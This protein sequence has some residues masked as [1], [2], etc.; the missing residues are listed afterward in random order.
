MAMKRNILLLFLL[1]IFSKIDAQ[2]LHL[3]M[4][5]DYA[6]PKFGIVSQADEE[7][8]LNVFTTVEWAI[9]YKLSTTYLNSNNKKFDSKNVLKSINSLQTKPED[10]IVLFYSGFG[11]YPT[12][13]ES[14]FPSFK[15]SDYKKAPLS[16]D[17]I[18]DKIKVKT[19]RLGIVLADCRDSFQPLSKG[20]PPPPPQ[21][22]MGLFEDFRRIMLRKIFLEKSGILKVASSS[23]GE[24]TWK[25]LK[26]NNSVFVSSFRS[27][28]GIQINSKSTAN[29]SLDS[30]LRISQSIMNIK[31]EEFDETKEQSVNWVFTPYEKNKIAL[32]KQY[33]FESFVIPSYDELKE[34]LTLIANSNDKIMR[35]SSSKKLI[36][37][38]TKDAKVELKMPEGQISTLSIENYISQ[39]AKY[40]KAI[41]RDIDF[42]ISDFKRSDDYKK[43]ISLRFTEKTN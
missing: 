29:V 21:D 40:D 30:V 26:K 4:V 38:F 8:I 24:S 23:K 35:D 9:N 42:K 27:A 41:K 39:T 2:T 10:M 3:I 32:F 5:S 13:S 22:G 18:A 33:N 36:E 6:D 34:E 16:L 28:I 31:L 37:M 14:T 20:P 7:S 43:F 15:L 1:L 17:D 19:I 25:L 11:Y 12:K